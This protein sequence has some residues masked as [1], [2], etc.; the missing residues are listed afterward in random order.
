MADKQNLPFIEALVLYDY[1]E[2]DIA[3]MTEEAVADAKRANGKAFGTQAPGHHEDGKLKGETAA[4]A[5]RDKAEV[6]RT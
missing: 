1:E 5:W 3:A 2:S 4:S 6:V